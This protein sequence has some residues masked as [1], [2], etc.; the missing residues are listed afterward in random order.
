MNM[1]LWARCRLY[2]SLHASGRRGRAA[3]VPDGE[4][5]PGAF[6]SVAQ[7]IRSARLSRP[8][9]AAGEGEGPWAERLCQSLEENDI[10]CTLFAEFGDRP[11]TAGGDAL[12]RAWTADRCDC[13]IALGGPHVIDLT[14]AAAR[15]SLSGKTILDSLGSGRAVRRPPPVFAVPTAAGAGTEV[16]GRVSAADPEG[17]FLRVEDPAL[18]PVCSVADPELLAQ[19][20]RPL[21]ADCVMDGICLAAEAFLSRYADDRTRT[22]AAEALRG[23]F[24]S[25]E[26]CWNSGGTLRERSRLLEA[27]RWAGL[28]ANRAGGGYARAL[29]EAW[30]D[31]TGTA[32]AEAFGM[33]LPSVLSQYGEHAASALSALAEQSGV[34]GSGTRAEKAS[35]LIG[36]LRSVSFRLGL[37]EKHDFP[38]D[39]AAA[40]IA[41]LAAAAADPRWACPVVWDEKDLARVF[42]N[43]FL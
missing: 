15:A 18:I 33:L 43:A 7:L 42:R 17:H 3:R 2:Q 35:A 38:D 26:P 25:A 4:D 21:L 6:Y 14:K 30:S 34:C 8:L 36:R 32:P 10:P 31:V 41:A 23:F 16:L 40:D 28:A 13:F 24:E 29:S 11:T 22:M 1:I 19:T 37:P 12:L 39:R 27:S 9:V 20:P 5:G